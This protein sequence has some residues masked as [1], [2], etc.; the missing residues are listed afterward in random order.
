VATI[1]NQQFEYAGQISAAGPVPILEP[2]V[3]I[4]DPRKDEAEAL[5][6]DALQ[7]R[8]AAL[9]DDAAVMV[10]LTIP[11]QPGRY[12]H[13][14]AG[15]RVVRVLALSGGYRRDK[16]CALLARDPSMI[17]SFSRALAP[18]TLS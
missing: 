3:S 10:K 16:A 8:I 13:L 11:T 5:L 17:A 15:P 4:D 9:P 7:T 12:A 6:R 1:A 14:A 18:R 2:E